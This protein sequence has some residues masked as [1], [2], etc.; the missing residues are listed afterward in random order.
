MSS[1]LAPVGSDVKRL[2]PLAFNASLRYEMIR[3]MWPA[4]VHDVL[5]VGCGL[6]SL[7]VRLA[8]HVR[9]VGLEPAEESFAVASERLA[10]CGGRGEVR[11]VMVRDLGD[12]QFDLVCAFEVLE[13]IEDDAAALKE[14]AGRLR[15][16]GWLMLSVPAHSDRF[17]PADEF[18]GHFRRYDPRGMAELLTGC[19]FR[20]VQLRL[21][22]FP[23]GYALETA[24]NVVARR[25][26]AAMAGAGIAERTAGSGRFLQPTTGLQGT[27]TDWG[28]LPFRLM[29]RA[30]PATG[31]GLVALARYEG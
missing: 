14:W 27:V 15:T 6:G 12:E 13:H 21:Y 11:N 4:G 24:R 31:T 25:R 5:E 7:G 9:Y 29:Q 10:A 28:T 26:L 22:G 8:Q 17:G 20:P 23:L 16:P 1:H 18:A 30:F 3:A 19:G 2:A